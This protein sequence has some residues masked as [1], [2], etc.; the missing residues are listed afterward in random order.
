MTDPFLGAG[1]VEREC[2]PPASSPQAVQRSPHPRDDIKVSRSS[3]SVLRDWRHSVGGSGSGRRRG[4]YPPIPHAPPLRRRAAL[5]AH[6]DCLTEAGSALLLLVVRAWLLYMGPCFLAVYPRPLLSEGPVCC[7]HY[8][9][10]HLGCPRRA[11]RL[12]ARAAATLGHVARGGVL[13]PGAPTQDGGAAAGQA[14]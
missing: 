8:L 4:S 10:P 9:H 7:L 11:H 14:L 3:E 13:L 5:G 2:S 12:M 6:P 1:V